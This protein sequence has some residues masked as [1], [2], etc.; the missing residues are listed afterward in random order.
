MA[1]TVESI[2]TGPYRDYLH[3]IL[4]EVLHGFSVDLAT[5]FGSGYDEILKVL[6]EFDAADARYRLSAEQAALFIH[7]SDLCFAEFDPDEFHTRLGFWQDEARDAVQQLEAIAGHEARTVKSSPTHE[8]R[9]ASV[10]TAFSPR[11][12]RAYIQRIR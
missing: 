9:D 6:D 4:N 1:N 12:G 10:G 7:A 11:S 3:N 2:A 8:A 5:E